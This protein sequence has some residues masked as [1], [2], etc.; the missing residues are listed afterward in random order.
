MFLGRDGFKAKANFDLSFFVAPKLGRVSR[1]AL[2]IEVMSFM[3]LSSWCLQDCQAANTMPAAAAA[4]SGA[5]NRVVRKDGRGS[6]FSSCK[7]LD[8]YCYILTVLVGDILAVPQ[9][10]N[11]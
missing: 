5:Q 8:C 3:P 11:C 2:W 10:L 4:P 1:A 9:C 7:D 6:T